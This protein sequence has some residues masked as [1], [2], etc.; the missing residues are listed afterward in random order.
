M[1]AGICWMG[2]ARPPL[3]RTA[4]MAIRFCH[5]VVLLASL[6]IIPSS[7]S[8]PWSGRSL[9]PRLSAGRANR[10]PPPPP[11]GQPSGDTEPPRFLDCPSDPLPTSSSS[12]PPPPPPPHVEVVAPR[13]KDG[14]VVYFSLPSALDRFD[15][16][17]A[18]GQLQAGSR[19]S[20]SFFPVGHHTVVVH[21]KD[22]AGNVAICSF[23]VAV[24]DEDPP[25]FLSCPNSLNL[26]I[27]PSQ[28]SVPIN[29]QTPEA[30][31]N[32]KQR[33]Q[34][35]HKQGPVPGDVARDSGKTRV[36]YTATDT[37]GNTAVCNFFITVVKRV[38]PQAAATGTAAPADVAGADERMFGSGENA[39]VHRRKQGAEQRARPL[40]AR[41]PLQRGST[42]GAGEGG[43]RPGALI[44]GDGAAYDLFATL[45]TT[46]AE[47]PAVP[48]ERSGRM[49]VGDNSARG[50]LF[51]DARRGAGGLVGNIAAGGGPL[52]GGEG[53]GDAGDGPKFRGV[54][55]LGEVLG[56]NLGGQVQSP[57]NNPGAAPA[58][59]GD[60]AVT[61][62][63]ALR[64]VGGSSSLNACADV[65]CRLQRGATSML[66]QATTGG[67]QPAATRAAGLAGLGLPGMAG[68]GG[69]YPPTQDAQRVQGNSYAQ[70][71]QPYADPYA[72]GL[73]A[74]SDPYAQRLQAQ[75]NP[76]AQRLQAQT[77]PYAQRLQAQ[78][79]PYAQRLQ[80]QSDPYAVARLDPYAQRLQAAGGGGPSPVGYAPTAAPAAGVG[81]MA[82][83]AA[84]FGQ[85][86][87]GFVNMWRGVM[88][89]R[90]LE[91]EADEKHSLGSPIVPIL[92]TNGI[93][94]GSAE[95]STDEEPVHPEH[96][97]WAT[98]DS[99]RSASRSQV[100]QPSSLRPVANLSPLD[101]H[102]DQTSGAPPYQSSVEA[103][104]PSRHVQRSS[105]KKERQQKREERDSNKE[106][107]SSPQTADAPPDR[108]PPHREMAENP[109]YLTGQ[110]DATRDW[111]AAAALVSPYVAP[112]VN[113][114]M[115]MV[116]QEGAST[117]PQ[118]M[119][120]AV[121]PYNTVSSSPL[122]PTYA[123]NVGAYGM[124]QRPADY[125]TGVRAITTGPAMSHPLM[126]PA[127]PPV[128]S[129]PVEFS[130]AVP[131]VSAGSSPED[132]L[133]DTS[134][135]DQDEPPTSQMH[136]EYLHKLQSYH[137]KY[138]Q[139]QAGGQ[140]REIGEGTAGQANIYD[141]MNIAKPPS[142]QVTASIKAPRAG[143]RGT[144][145][146]GR[147]PDLQAGAR[148][149]PPLL[150]TTS[151]L[152][153]PGVAP[154][155]PLDG[156]SPGAV[157][158]R[159]SKLH[160]VYQIRKDIMRR[161]ETAGTSPDAPL[162]A[163]TASH[164][165]EP[166]MALQQEKK[167]L[168]AEA[169]GADIPTRVAELLQSTIDGQGVDTSDIASSVT[170]EG[171]ATAPRRGDDNLSPLVM[172][173]KNLLLQSSNTAA[174]KVDTSY[175]QPP[176]GPNEVTAAGTVARSADDVSTRRNAVET[177]LGYTNPRSTSAGM[178]GRPRESME[179]PITAP[180]RLG[181]DARGQRPVQHVRRDIMASTLGQRG[182]GQP[183]AGTPWREIA[184]D[185]SL[186]QMVPIF[187]G[188]VGAMRS[189]RQAASQTNPGTV[190]GGATP[191]APT[192]PVLQ[193]SFQRG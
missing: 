124:E 186:K 64:D 165:W 2:H 116:P 125:S 138:S 105:R 81:Q 60:G 11:G 77:D 40:A 114:F 47:A 183:V 151:G 17:R 49:R 78:S 45:Q 46:E 63:F 73:Q 61:D 85:A 115:G 150:K 14:A 90:R 79:D 29:Y 126:R 175:S 189:F 30:I 19:S 8:S 156:L 134:S 13:G 56:L 20:G 136:A 87:N 70:R 68:Y 143:P 42:V 88:G 121:Q 55:G 41:G 102:T 97:V 76:Y 103:S 166:N 82:A 108:S 167:T 177:G 84:G 89:A 128:M 171:N 135:Q 36:V 66:M 33:V 15:G 131:V 181:R 75:T 123:A 180:G 106:A 154:V 43:G 169:A 174:G 74:M 163:S 22:K 133:L 4:T 173:A 100:T 71:L 129:D 94:E 62:E 191:L 9:R 37:S 38:P 118:P 80:A 132:A 182:E 101:R 190:V 86:V 34:V 119:A 28:E 111:S 48:A 160:E 44:R 54:G 140:T 112:W 72:H 27:E 50:E 159:R 168:R 192:D 137:D 5:L 92:E 93:R 65:K 83:G 130:S 157:A 164:S 193:T 104:A 53:R 117:G 139:K 23:V 184:I 59:G 58:G 158:N 176:P 152:A 57:A 188:V 96:V 31:D 149:V 12:R 146:D 170:P 24:K 147:K 187:Q 148:V 172:R 153:K 67:Q 107:D 122:P 39:G 99:T 6:L 95:V 26:I 155:I 18:D 113:L 1:T 52:R 110:A 179:Q 51:A 145:Q 144:G 21:A 35:K 32:S 16:T 178:T 162:V 161:G 127:A 91:S 109:A 142:R 141:M 25:T 7:T 3:Q 69:A 98:Y 185:E 10:P 120:P